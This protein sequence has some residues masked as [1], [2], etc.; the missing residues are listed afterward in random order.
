MNERKLA[1]VILAA[2]VGTRMKSR[3]PKVLHPLAGLPML[4]HVIGC[5]EQLNPDAILVVVGPDMPGVEKAAAPYPC[6]VQEERLGTGHA[7]ES[8]RAALSPYCQAAVPGPDLSP[9][10]T[11][12]AADVLV[13]YGDTPFLTVATLDRMRQMRSLPDAPSII[14]LGF[15]PSDTQGYGRIDLTGG[16]RIAR[17]V[18][19]IDATELQRK[20]KLCNAGI[21]LAQGARL[22]ELLGRLD[23]N[24]AKGELYLTDIYG[25]AAA[26]GEP[27]GLVR[28]EASEV[29]G[30]NSKSELAQAE[31]ILQT[32]L[33]EEAMTGGVTLTDPKS[34][35]LSYDTEFGQDVVIQPNVFF[36]PGVSVG[37]NVEIR[38]FSHI[39]GATI[40]NNTIVGPFARLRPGSDLKADSRVGN[41]VE[42]KNAVLGEGAK[43]NHLTY[44]GDASVGPGA[45]IGAGTITCN[46]DGYGKYCT[47]IGEGAFIGSNS[48]LVAPV[49]VGERA[50]VGA[51]SVITGDVA[52]DAL[53]VARGQQRNLDKGGAK[54]RKRAAQRAQ[55]SKKKE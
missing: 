10:G 27:A 13:V 6:V 40:G 55:A 33:R 50:T 28:A 35:W 26:D 36:G 3:L 30:I 48:A 1:V 11:G 32:R 16:E 23:R 12:D 44:L 22:M 37:D 29:L 49:Q 21:L 45:N 25:L 2:G 7:V 53:A 17:V 39:E 52:P 5:V 4:R 43:A 41:F 34:V 46:Y 42:I 54:L 9:E 15:E 14:G 20:V 19:H 51:G 47:V 8:A 18:E 24:N 31:L 38:A